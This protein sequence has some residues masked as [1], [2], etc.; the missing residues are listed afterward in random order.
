[1]KRVIAKTVQNER[2]L[3][4]SPGMW[5]T[6]A[7]IL[8]LAGGWVAVCRRALDVPSLFAPALAT[9]GGVALIALAT[10]LQRRRL[11]H[12][13]NPAAQPEGLLP[14]VG[15]ILNQ[16]VAKTDA[17]VILVNREGRVLWVNEGFVR[18]T[19]YSLHEV[20]GKRPVEF[21]A[22]PETDPGALADL[23]CTLDAGEPYRGEILNYTKEGRRYHASFEAL[24]ILDQ[25]GQLKHVVA[26]GRDVTDR[27]RAEQALHEEEGRYRAIFEAATDSLL[28]FDCQGTVIEA[29]PAAC[30][31]YGYPREELL[32]ISGRQIVH[33]DYT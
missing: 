3:I 27:V 30:A 26:I 1:M 10:L 7:G 5:L 23:K 20:R 16:V 18:L 9:F 12:V 33:P 2:S 8:L 19:G 21:L 31:L 25:N 15:R 22:G 4:G 14:S 29:N 13:R 17:A 24:P 32:G 28:I 11:V 6:A